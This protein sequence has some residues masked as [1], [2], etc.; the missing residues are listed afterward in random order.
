MP[1]SSLSSPWSAP[2]SPRGVWLAPLHFI[3]IFQVVLFHVGV[4]LFLIT[5]N[6]TRQCLICDIFRVDRGFC[7][8]ALEQL[9]SS[10]P[11][12]A[13][14][15]YSATVFFPWEFLP[16]SNMFL[17]VLWRACGSPPTFWL[18]LSAEEFLVSSDLQPPPRSACL[19]SFLSFPDWVCHRSAPIV[20]ATAPPSEAP[21]F[22][23]RSGFLTYG[24]YGRWMSSAP[25]PAG[26]THS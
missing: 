18:H 16:S 4:V 21:S 24:V 2:S 12:S 17:C 15:G 14:L 26:S 13:T 5:S 1:V 3:N 25:A 11:S 22:L 19:D 6:F 10:Y 7:D 23:L 8:G 9:R 20:S